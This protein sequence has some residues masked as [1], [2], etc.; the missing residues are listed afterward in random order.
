M[1]YIFSKMSLLPQYLP[2][3]TSS[4][5]TARQGSTLL[6]PCLQK[7]SRA[8]RELRVLVTR[9][10]ESPHTLAKRVRG[11]DSGG[12][13]PHHHQVAPRASLEP[14]QEASEAGVGVGL[15]AAG[16]L[17]PG[18]PPLCRGAASRAIQFFC[19]AREQH[20]CVCTRARY[21]YIQ[22]W[23]PNQRRLEGMPHG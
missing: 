12:V 23:S 8:Q 2:P 4:P 15:C 19:R 3:T 10:A 22:S 5:S 16:K 9:A 21:V 20:T 18:A 14:N 1:Q 17:R 7:L 11:R 13:Y 6:S